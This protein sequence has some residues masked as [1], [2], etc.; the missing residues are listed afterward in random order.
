MM[1]DSIERVLILD[2]KKDEIAALKDKL[3]KDDIDVTYLTPNEAMTKQLKKS[4]Q[5]LFFDLSLDDKKT[6]GVNIS[7][8]RRLLKKL[9][10]KDFGAYGLI[11]WTSHVHDIQTLKN[12]IQ[13]DGK[14]GKYP[15]PLFILGMSKLDYIRKGN[16]NSI[17]EDLE[18]LLINN[19]AAYFFF[20]WSASIYSG[21]NKAISDIYQLEPEYDK[22]ES[23]LPYLLYLM[24]MNYTGIPEDQI[25]HYDLTLDAYKAFDELLYSD[26][27]SQQSK[28][29]N[30]F[31]ETIEKPDYSFEKE[32]D[33]IAKINSRQLLDL[34]ITDQSIVLP[35]NVYQIIKDNS[36]LRLEG[37]PKKA[38][39]NPIPIAIEMTPPCDFSHKK[40]SS[41]LVGGFMINCPKESKKLSEY[42]NSKF[43]ADSKY[44]IWPINYED[45]VRFVCFD[46]RNICVES[47]ETLKDA[48]SYKLLFMVKHNLFADILQKF[49][50]HVARLGLS[51]V[52][53]DLPK[54]VSK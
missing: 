10:P 27:I 21:V 38:K 12:A 46:F 36:Y 47:D 31:P 34:S 5:L 22:Q 16:Y 9:L 54:Y 39:Y 42:V 26:L 17:L 33:Q 28:L 29:E 43:K 6:I 52:Q 45:K 1:F 18:D 40:L 41:R 32:L 35:G 19:K 13:E 50:S 30:I 53:P 20:N 51:I 44:L 7:T 14:N 24:A 25:G 8:I 48:E 4:R 3:E 15:I 23:N 49:S 2:D 11:M 37:A